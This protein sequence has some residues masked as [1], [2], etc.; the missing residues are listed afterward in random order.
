VRRAYH[1]A[2]RAWKARGEGRTLFLCTH[3]MLE[4]EALCDR[5]LAVREG[6]LVADRSV[7]EL[8]RATDR[9]RSLEDVILSYYATPS[10]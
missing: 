1:E 8:K 4:V 2:I 6:R 10:P 7:E 9:A 5:V 3:D